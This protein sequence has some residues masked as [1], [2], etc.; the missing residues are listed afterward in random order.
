MSKFGK[1]IWQDLTV[2]NAVEVKDFYCQVVGWSSSGV[3]QGD[4]EDFNIINKGDNDQIVAGICHK[5]GDIKNFPSQWLL[6][7]TVENLD[8]SI[9]KCRSLGGK[10][11]EGPGNMGKALYAIIQDP[12][13]AYM[14]LF[15]E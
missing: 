6:Y 8:H 13:G 1:I 7:V 4:Y 11:I 10:I 5:R 3:D 12:A 14:A 9:E 2:E 15:Q